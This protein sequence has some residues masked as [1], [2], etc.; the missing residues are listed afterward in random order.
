M[1]Y[2][3]Y[4]KSIQESPKTCPAMD[5]A[6]DDKQARAAIPP[7]PHS[8]TSSAKVIAEYSNKNKILSAEEILEHRKYCRAKQGNCPFE[9]ARDEADDI[10]PTDIHITKSTVFS[11]LS[12]LM[13]QMFNMAKNL[14]LPAIVDTDKVAEKADKAD[15][16]EDKPTTDAMPTA[17]AQE[18]SKLVAE[19][20]EKG[21]EAMST[22]AKNNGCNV[23]MDEKKS[24]YIVDGPA[25][26]PYSKS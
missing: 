23:T 17:E 15:V 11:R 12:V 5:D 2:F 3:E 10:T 8:Q 26:N 13:T 4:E 22:M 18:D 1:N 19:I 21:I 6:V 14:A 25:K 24:K 7:A 20:I 9:K 16:A